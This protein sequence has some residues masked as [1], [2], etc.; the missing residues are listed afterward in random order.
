MKNALGIALPDQIPGYGVV[1]PYSGVFTRLAPRANVGG[2]AKPRTPGEDKVLPNLK[3]AILRSGLKDGMT[4]SF[5]HHL[6][7]G[8][9]VVNQVMQVIAELGLKDLCVAASG[10]FAVHEPL[11]KLIEAGVITQIITSTFNSGPVPKAITAG[12]LKK[13]CIMMT[14]GGRPQA[15][16]NGSLHIDVAFIAAPTADTQGNLN[17][18]DGPS[19]CGYLSYAYADAEYA[20]CVVA[21]TDHLVA[22]PACPIEISQEKVDYIVPVASIGDP[23][24]I[25]SGTTRITTDPVRLKIASDTA[26]LME[27]TGAICEGMSFQT[28]A[29]ST[30]LAVADDVRRRMLEQHI[31][32]SFALGGIHAYMVKMLEEEL[33]H[34]L[35][36]TQCFDL[37]AIRSARENTNHMAISASQYANP[38][39]GSPVV[40]CLDTVILGATEIDVNFNVNVTTGSNGVIMGAAGGHSD[41]AAGSKL[42]IIVA[43]LTRKKFCVV[44]DH[45]T[46]ITT[47]GDT[48]DA[49]VTE[50][51][52]AINP[53]RTDLLEQLK[54]SGLP[55]KTIAELKHIGEELVGPQGHA[56]VTD[57][58][59]GIVEYRDGSVIDLVYQPEA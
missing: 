47:P 4:V 20:D 59:V 37:D 57:H 3:T 26:E 17:G 18:T 33:F 35:L 9:Q 16:M 27:Q 40:N 22:Y 46:T 24:G 2:R 29:S 8:D 28:G 12:K 44:R 53:R 15:I 50:Y 14:H 51:G 39:S 42:A 38:F 41:C 55:L 21:V 56:K 19:A 30:A 58:I 48:I 23:G 31:T 1:T 6:R 25:V 54:D 45:V 36:D 43:N 11:V 49:L 52:I 32:G 10:I 34:A 5:H 7:N 13:P